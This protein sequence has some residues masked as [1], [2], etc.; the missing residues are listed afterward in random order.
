MK[1][2][3]DMDIDIGSL[4]IILEVDCIFVIGSLH[5]VLGLFS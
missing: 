5:S 2:V 1:I 3:N 4:K